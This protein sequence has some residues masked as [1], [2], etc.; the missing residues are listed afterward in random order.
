MSDDAKNE[1]IDRSRIGEKVLVAAE[2]VYPGS[3]ISDLKIGNC[4]VQVPNADIQTAFAVDDFT[5]TRACDAYEATP[6]AMYYRDQYEAMR[7]ALLTVIPALPV[8]WVMVPRNP[9]YEMLVAG[10][11]AHRNQDHD[12]DD[13]LRPVYKAMVDTAPSH[14]S[15]A[16]KID[17]AA[18][19]GWWQIVQLLDRIA[20]EWSDNEL[21]GGDAAVLAINTLIET[22]MAGWL[23][24]TDEAH[25]TQS[26]HLG[27]HEG[28]VYHAMQALA[29]R[30]GAKDNRPMFTKLE[31][32]K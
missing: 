11:E 14:P 26:R 21:S 25:K 31:V 12:K 4:I 16:E 22:A 8:D 6:G 18:V 19:D 32:E 24:M 3:R 9:N 5:V 10:A 7:S 27:K 23:R 20:P 17:T 28:D 13:T 15:V 2:I 1:P 30:F 29:S